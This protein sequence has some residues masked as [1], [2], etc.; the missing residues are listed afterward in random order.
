MT[1]DM[2]M[3]ALGPLDNLR[4]L[5]LRIPKEQ[6][7]QERAKSIRVTKQAMVE[8]ARGHPVLAFVC[9]G[10][11]QASLACAEPRWH[12]DQSTRIQSRLAQ[13]LAISM[14]RL[15][16]AFLGKHMTNSRGRIYRSFW[17]AHT[18]ASHK[19]PVCPVMIEEPA[20]QCL[21]SLNAD[22]VVEGMLQCR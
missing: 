21:Q 13:L 3:Q 6:M 18:I 4:R 5:W 17:Y 15:R 10:N 16:R 2:A 12:L 11:Q 22:V 20:Q 19:M 9:F 8:L 14:T 7:W 1:P